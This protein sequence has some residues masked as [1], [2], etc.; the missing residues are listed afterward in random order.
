MITAA[1]CAALVAGLGIASPAAGSASL[2]SPVSSPGAQLWA[3]RYDGPAG[4]FA[5]NAAAMAV[6]PS[7]RMVYVTGTSTSTR[8]EPGP[9]YVTIGY[10]ASTG[11]R[12]WLA[13]YNGPASGRDES[14]AVAV[15]PDGDRVYVTGFSAKHSSGTDYVTIAYDA[16]TG[17]RLW[18]ARYNDPANGA[19]YARSVA[20]SPDGSAVYVT[21]QASAAAAAYVYATVAYNA[22][23]GAQLWVSDYNG[24][25]R[26]YSAAR[27][28]AVGPDSHVLYVTGDSGASPQTFSFVT[29]AYDAA[30]GA[31]LWAASYS[32]PAGNNNV[33]A[34]A[35]SPDGG[36]V[37]V[38]GTSHEPA[39]GTAFATV[40][41]HAATGARLWARR[42]GRKASIR[43][44]ALALAV[45]PRRA[46]VYVTGYS[47]N[48][49]ATL[50]YRAASG[51]QLW[52]SRY[53]AVRSSEALSVAVS[54]DGN[55]LYI[56]GVTYTTVAY[57]AAAGTLLW[58]SH[59]GGPAG[60]ANNATAVVVSRG[61][62]VIITGNSG[63]RD[64]SQVAWATVAYKPN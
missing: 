32:G 38:I 36:T 1:A 31:Q 53:K 18:L 29:V 54:P 61:G 8:S 58:A 63:S 41:Y 23:T 44:A 37:F 20:V 60:S 45:A 33:S 35:V 57:R 12:R 26:G 55:T 47:G 48:D 49:Y 39:S 13:R 17:A 2:R 43:S 30:T 14:D 56:T 11:A 21:G 46:A 22:A 9:D 25:A 15:S 16:A 24:P 52:A 62:E 40:A 5:N 34:V 42:Y 3:E 19:D 7:E 27:S 10:S 28:L 6:S 51:A 64:S 4:T 50:A 59:Y